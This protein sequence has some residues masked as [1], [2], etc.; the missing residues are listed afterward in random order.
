[1]AF[2]VTEHL[3]VLLLLFAY[4]AQYTQGFTL[5]KRYHV[6]ISNGLPVNS[7]DLQIHVFSGDN[8]LGYHNLK[9]NEIFSWEFEMNLFQNTKFYSHF[10]W[11][12]KERSFAVFDKH[13]APKCGPYDED[14]CFWIAKEDGFYFAGINTR[15]EDAQKMNWWV[16]KTTM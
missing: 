4:F 7:Q 2:T 10:S 8:D 12:D 15:H 9:V 14:T 16:N 6:Y 1:M 5:F 11:G 13:I 3:F